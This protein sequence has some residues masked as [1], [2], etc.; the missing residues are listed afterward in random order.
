M[1]PAKIE[2]NL[3]KIMYDRGISYRQLERMSGV[4]KSML[5]AIANGERIPS[6]ETAFDI[7]DALN[8]TINELFFRKK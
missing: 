1:V 4:S 3:D 2:S 5:N 7:A 8:V 6:L